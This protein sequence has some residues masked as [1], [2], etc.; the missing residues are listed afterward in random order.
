MRR[1]LVGWV[2][3]LSQCVVAGTAFGGTDYC[4]VSFVEESD[5]FYEAARELERSRDA[6]IVLARADELDSLLTEL[7]ALR[8]RYVAVVIRPNML[9]ENVVR[10]FMKL[11]T[12]LDDDP[13][14]DFAYGFITGD[15]AE[16]AVA[17]ARA[18][19]RVEQQRKK[20]GVAMIAVAGPGLKD[21]VSARQMLPHRLVAV[22]EQHLGERLLHVKASFPQP[23][24]QRLMEFAQAGVEATFEITATSDSTTVQILRK[25]MAP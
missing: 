13:F 19:T 11:A 6:R 12:R 4:V 2:A 10:R 24:M 22:V 16:V 17:L 25:E 20:P 21:S 9:D 5:P 23:E 18:G 8:P 3:C 1:F 15:S 7:R 14:L